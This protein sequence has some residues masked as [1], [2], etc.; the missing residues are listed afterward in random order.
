[1]KEFVYSNKS[2]ECCY[3]CE[4]CKQVCPYKAISMESN[5]EGFLYPHIDVTKCVEC[6]L[7][8]RVCPTQDENISKL[9]YPTPQL[10][11]AAWNKNLDERLESTSGGVFYLLAYQ[12][13]SNGGIVYGADYSEDFAVYHRRF[14]DVVD[15]NRVRGSKYLQSNIGDAFIQ[16]KEDIESGK[17]V[18]FS[19]TPCQIAG[20]RLFLRKPYENLYTVDLVCHGVPSPMFFKQHI[21]YLEQKYGKHIVDFKFRAKKRSGWRSYVKYV[22][23]QHRPIYTFWGDNYYTHAFNEGYFNRESCFKCSFSTSQRVGDITLSDFWG[24]EAIHK[25]LRRVRKYGFNC[26]I[27][28]TSKGRI[29]FDSINTKLHVKEYP[30]ETAIQGDV[31]LRHS[32]TR[33]VLRGNAYK[34]LNKEGYAYMQDT[35]G[36]QKSLTRRIIPIWVKNIIREL[37]SY[38][39]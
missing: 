36:I 22:F 21:K 19:G 8:E 30:I 17:E 2:K 33:P 27:C 37:Q 1:M 4:A 20:L 24:A 18:L 7:C 26:V 10:V 23:N 39:K 9:F 14:D 25:E 32:E 15:L 35:Y 28:N 12:F 13:V 29:L 11:Y 16:V 3:G 6:G 5:D 38:Y 31:R 34:L